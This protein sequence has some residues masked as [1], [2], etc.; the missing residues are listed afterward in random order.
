MQKQTVQ[1]TSPI[2][3]LVAI[4]KRL[5]SYENQRGLASEEFFDQYQNG[6]LSDEVVF[7]EWANDYQ[8]YLEIRLE[9]EKKLQHAA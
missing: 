4:T 7:V 2:D 1:Y 6:H 8:H 9:L 3:A 5:N